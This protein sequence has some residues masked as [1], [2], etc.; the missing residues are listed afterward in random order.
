MPRVIDKGVPFGPKVE[1]APD[2]GPT[3]A[4]VNWTGR[5]SR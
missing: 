3:E 4:M 1:P 5:A 2:A